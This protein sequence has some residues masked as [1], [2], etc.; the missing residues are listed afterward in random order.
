MGY[1][2]FQNKTDLTLNH[3]IIFKT[4][5]I[6]ERVN[7]ASVYKHGKFQNKTDLTLN[8]EINIQLLF[9]RERV[10]QKGSE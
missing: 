2:K 9:I 3:E 6:R 7:K 5:V 10:S 4:S 1:F 8:H